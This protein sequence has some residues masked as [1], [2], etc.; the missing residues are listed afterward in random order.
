MFVGWEHN[1]VRLAR[2][3][4]P[5][6]QDCNLTHAGITQQ[7]WKLISGQFPSVLLQAPVLSRTDLE[8]HGLLMYVSTK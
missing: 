5:K 7:N 8:S 6:L 3:N 2:A 4:G 1:P